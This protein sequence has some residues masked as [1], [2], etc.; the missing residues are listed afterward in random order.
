[1]DDE[2][3]HEVLS[4]DKRYVGLMFKVHAT[5]LTNLS[6]ARSFKREGKARLKNSFLSKSHV[7]KTEESDEESRKN[8]RVR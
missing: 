4:H 5:G 2:T 3:G 8:K 6:K 1:M 7:A